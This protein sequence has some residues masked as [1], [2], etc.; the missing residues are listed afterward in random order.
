MEPALQSA[1]VLGIER[2]KAWSDLLDNINVFPVADGDTGRNLTSSLTPLRA[3]GDDRQHTIL[4]LLMASR[5]NSGSIATR[6]LSGMLTADSVDQL[7]QAARLGRDNAWQAI[8]SPIP[9]TMLTVFDALVAALEGETFENEQ[10]CIER[11]I[12]Q[13][14]QAVRSTRDLLPVLQQAG[15]VDSG[16]L[17]MYVFLEGF[18]L[19]LIEKTDELMPITRRFKGMLKIS[20]QFREPAGDGFCV[21]TV[22]QLADGESPADLVSDLGDSAVVIPHEKY[23]KIHLHTDDR[24][25]MHDRLTALGRIVEWEDSD[26]GR[27]VSEFRK[28][29]AGQ[30]IHLMTDAAGSFTKEDAKQHGIT[31]LDSY[32]SAG[33]KMQPETH[34][35]PEEL[36]R[37]MSAGVRVS[38]AQASEFERHQYYQRVLEEYERVLY[39]CVGSVFTGNYQVA[40]RWKA[41][42]D[43]EDRFTIIDSGAASG[44]LGTIVL[45]TARYADRAT[46][47]QSVIDFARNAIDRCEEY[48]FLDKLQYLAAGGRL[49]KTSAF[50]GDT[51]R[52]KPIV[53]PRPEGAVKVGTARNQ[54]GQL[55]FAIEKLQQAVDRDST[56]LIMLEYSDN[57]AWVEAVVK[58]AVLNVC[59]SADIIL[60]PL[61]LTSGVHMGPG[62]WALAFLLDPSPQS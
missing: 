15:V 9:G 26:I 53:S 20:P 57:H 42:N 24:K 11:I 16:A 32:I 6:F 60:Q 41:E 55:K 19:S 54:A 62:T 37:L 58:T 29:G 14:E 39:L 52:I 59:P 34:F 21:D 2:V 12:D 31:L 48:V 8:Q 33:D 25:D 46:E 47:A 56:P 61:S 28:P 35:S 38:T 5:G 36:Y 23:L 10:A 40:T 45:A 51:L 1:Y 18:L 22:I 30:V 43:P 50:F 4:R 44:R 17:G 3:L 7:P 13:L 27:Q 49:S